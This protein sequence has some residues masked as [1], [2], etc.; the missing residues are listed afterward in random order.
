MMATS[1]VARVHERRQN[2]SI[3]GD[4]R[5]DDRDDGDIHCGE[6]QIEMTEKIA[7]GTWPINEPS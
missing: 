1:I 4:I 7:A 2:G 5:E 6:M 3:W